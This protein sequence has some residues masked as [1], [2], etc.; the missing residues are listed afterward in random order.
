MH[1]KPL[2]VARSKNGKTGDVPT[3]FVGG[4]RE[5]AANSCA[6]CSHY[7]TTCYAWRGRVGMGAASVWRA[8]SKGKD[9]SLDTALKRAARSARMV[10]VSAIGDVAAL[11]VEYVREMAKQVARE[12]LDLVGYTSRWAT[13][14]HLKDVVLASVPNLAAA[15]TAISEGWKVAV[16][17][18]ADHEGGSFTTPNGVKGRV[19]PAILSKRVTCNTCRL[20]KSGKGPHIGFPLHR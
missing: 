13:S 16:T 5:E 14:P 15:D 3:L 4:T 20:C 9:Y 19:C 17:L 2:W 10:R 7:G 1:A 11:P 12:G 8:A 6:G 18:P